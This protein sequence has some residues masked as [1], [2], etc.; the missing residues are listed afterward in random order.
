ML[1]PFPPSQNL[2]VVLHGVSPLDRY[3]EYRVRIR[4][5]PFDLHHVTP[6]DLVDGP[7]VGSPC[8]KVLTN[9][10]L[11]EQIIDMYQARCGPVRF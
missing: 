3:L 4:H 7:S 9:T 5:V 8:V 2:G 1:V 10:V 11:Q 6:S